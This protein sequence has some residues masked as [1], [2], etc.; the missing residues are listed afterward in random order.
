MPPHSA[1][2]SVLCRQASL[3]ANILTLPHL[4]QML[5]SVTSFSILFI[6]RLFL[7]MGLSYMP[8]FSRC[9]LLWWIWAPCSSWK[10]HKALSGLSS[11]WMKRVE[12]MSTRVYFPSF[13]SL[14]SIWLQALRTGD[15]ITFISRITSWISSL[16]SRIDSAT[17]AHSSVDRQMLEGWVRITYWL[18]RVLLSWTWSNKI[19]ADQSCEYGTYLS[20]CLCL[21]GL[22]FVTVLHPVWCNISN[23]TWNIYWSCA[24]TACVLI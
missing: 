13:C 17:A 7:G 6:L 16:R 4:G 3:R 2:I 24:V 5:W 12:W 1:M 11:T 9:S 21:M 23:E 14:F 15:Y 19:T 10:E 22:L 20:Q 8:F 18:D